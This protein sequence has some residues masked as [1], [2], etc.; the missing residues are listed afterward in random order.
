MKN[1]RRSF[2]LRAFLRYLC[3][4]I[5]FSGIFLFFIMNICVLVLTS[6]CGKKTNKALG[7]DY[8]KLAMLDLTDRQNLAMQQDPVNNR[9]TSLLAYKKALC[10]I[11]QA[12]AQD[13]QARYVAL[14]ATLLF[15]LGQEAAGSAC[16][17]DALTLCAQDE[18]LKAEILNNY[19][20]S[21]AQN[22]K[23]EEALGIWQELEHNEHYLSP[24]VACV[25]QGKL[26]AGQ[27]DLVSAKRSL[28]KAI[29]VSPSYIDAH[30]YTAMLAHQMG[31]LS[32][33]KN[34][35]KTILFLEPAHTG[36]A[37]LATYLDKKTP[38]CSSFQRRSP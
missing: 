22:N 4:Y 38:V 13:N 1:Q 16:F 17:K 30:Y 9:N 5:Y 8:Y 3:F 14:K 26:Y 37:Q 24:E 32:L 12:I 29:Q 2:R 36:A 31:D 7:R 19:A 23:T 6:S 27:G 20:C 33:A 15:L 11:N 34:E 21:C 25:N 10:N 28:L 18:Q 35:V